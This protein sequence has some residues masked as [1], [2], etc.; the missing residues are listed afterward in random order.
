LLALE[1]LK[2]DP[3]SA[4]QL[5]HEVLARELGVLAPALEHV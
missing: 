3:S 4:R 5:P 1:G 2:D